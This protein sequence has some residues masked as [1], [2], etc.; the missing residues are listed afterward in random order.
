ML[1]LSLARLQTTV[2]GFVHTPPPSTLGRGTI[3]ALEARLERQYMLLQTLLMLLLEKKVIDEN[4]FREWVTYV[5]S[6]DGRTDGRLTENKAP[7]DCPSC[8]R[9]NPPTA[10][11]CQY[12]GTEMAAQI[13]DP[14]H[15]R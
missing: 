14:R 10:V 5:D 12:C 1:P 8:R 6:L 15:Q 4:E 13:I 9:R 7:I 11:R 2:D 3:E